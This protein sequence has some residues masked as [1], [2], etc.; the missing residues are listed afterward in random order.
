G[1]DRALMDAPILTKEGEDY[2]L[3]WPNGLEA[4]VRYLTQGRDGPRGEVRVSS[5]LVGHLHQ[6]MLNLMSG[7]SRDTFR[8]ALERRDKEVDWQAHIEQICVLVV[9]AYR[10]GD[11]LT[12]LEPQLR[13]QESAYY[14]SPLIPTGVPT[15][16]YGDGGTGKSYI[17]AAIGRALTLGIPFAGMQAR[18][19]TVAYL[20]WE[21][22]DEE[23][24]DR[25]YRLGSDVTYFYRQCSVPLAHQTRIL[26]RMFDKHGIDF[27]I[28]DSLG[29]ACG[30][31]IRDPDVVLAFFSALR[32]LNRTSF[33]VHHVPKDSKEPYGSV[34]IRNSVRSAWY[35]MRSTLPE[36]DSFCA[37]LR[38][39]KTNRGRFEQPIGLQFSFT[40]ETTTITRTDVSRIP[41]LGEGLSL[42]DRILSLLAQKPLEAK[43]IALELGTKQTHIAARLT[44]LRQ[45]KKVTN[46]A[47]IWALLDQVH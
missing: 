3:T 30:G 20:D 12:L 9:E 5:K 1:R 17:A 42:R 36:P 31:D 13:S 26:G 10:A 18:E 40:E 33:V 46:V 47:G 45:A 25:L 34:Y 4:E 27:I 14:I 24:R 43:D 32:I 21:W 23:H 6:S 19:A 28:V 38:H 8:K 16:L 11:P 22:D 15:L 7:S 39:G 29:Y 2:R 44:E 37:A 41:E 35:M